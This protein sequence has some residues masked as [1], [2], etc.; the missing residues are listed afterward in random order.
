[1]SSG[2]RNFFAVPDREFKA[3]FDPLDCESLIRKMLVLQ[4]NKR[5]TIEQMKHHRWMMVE[6]LDIPIIT[7]ING[8][9][10]TA[11]CEPNDQILRIMQNLGIDSQRTRE[12]LKVRKKYFIRRVF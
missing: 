8:V 10:G 12:S 9:G 11:A 1:M 6:V 7:V 3:C 5:I 2:K 4:P